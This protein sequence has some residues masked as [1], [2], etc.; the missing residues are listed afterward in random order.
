MNLCKDRLS[1]FH[2]NANEMV[3][4]PVPGCEHLGEVITKA[5]CRIEHGL[6]QDEVRELHGTGYRV[7]YN[8][9]VFKHGV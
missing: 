5:H 9:A 3:K 1:G 6:T 7:V 2:A 8:K 4:C